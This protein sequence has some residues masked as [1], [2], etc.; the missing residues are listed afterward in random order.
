VVRALEPLSK[1]I[2]RVEH[3]HYPLIQGF[4]L[5]IFIPVARLVLRLLYVILL[6]MSS[7]YPAILLRSSLVILGG[8]SSTH[9]AR[10]TNEKVEAG[11]TVG[12][13]S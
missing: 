8:A 7:W 3:P 5:V 2:G 4:L 1:P 12:N 13:K 9:Y 10:E 6:Y 11:V